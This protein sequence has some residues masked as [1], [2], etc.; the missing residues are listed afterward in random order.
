MKAAGALLVLLL[1]LSEAGAQ[2]ERG[3][4]N[5]R[6]NHVEPGT[7]LQPDLWDEVKRLRDMVHSMGN[8]VVVQGEKLKNV[9]EEAKEQRDL[10]SDLRLEL[11]IT[12]HEMQGTLKEH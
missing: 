11:A 8:T 6:D 2:G 10:V 9:E 4:L 12:K 3:A 1:C 5:E 7:L